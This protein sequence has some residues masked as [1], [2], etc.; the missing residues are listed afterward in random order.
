MQ[1]N[2]T[3]EQL[4]SEI[5]RSEFPN[6]AKHFDGV[7]IY[8]HAMGLAPADQTDVNELFHKRGTQAAMTECFNIWNQHNPFAATYGA[9]LELLLRLRKDKIADLICQH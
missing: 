2:L 9:L 1:Y 4:N 3:D 6:L 5:V 7:I 8:S